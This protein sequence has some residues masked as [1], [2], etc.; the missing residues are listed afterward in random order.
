ML[1]LFKDEI[2]NLGK[3][4]SVIEKMVENPRTDLEEIREVIS[5]HIIEENEIPPD[6]DDKQRDAMSISYNALDDLIDEL[7]VSE[8]NSK[9]IM[10]YI[11][12]YHSYNG[13]NRL[14]T[15]F[16]SLLTETERAR[17]ISEGKRIFVSDITE[18]WN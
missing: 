18:H 8:L 12:G 2:P 16:Q 17:L 1:E 13:Y 11:S 5:D 15:D 14:I 4:I 6:D 9:R 3:L 7:E 10:K